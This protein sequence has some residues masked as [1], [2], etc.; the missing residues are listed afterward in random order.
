M[1][2]ETDRTRAEARKK[3]ND[4]R[5]A[6]DPPPDNDRDDKLP[7]ADHRFRDWALI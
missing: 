3:E 5:P 6:D 1:S 4:A 2:P 7:E